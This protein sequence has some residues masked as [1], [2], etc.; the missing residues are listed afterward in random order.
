MKH[1]KDDQFISILK[2]QHSNYQTLITIKITPSLARKIN[3]YLKSELE[4]PET[5]SDCMTVKSYLRENVFSSEKMEI[6]S[7][8]QIKIMKHKTLMGIRHLSGNR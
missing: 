1:T 2:F 6:K 4:L 8:F 7:G 5:K 3:K